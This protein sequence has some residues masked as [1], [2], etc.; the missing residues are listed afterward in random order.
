MLAVGY[1]AVDKY[2]DVRQEQQTSIFQQGAQF[3]YEQAIVQLMEQASTCQ[4]V[5]IYVENQTMNL[6]SVECLQNK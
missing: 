6:V 1:I 4:Q 3:G 2:V 5:P